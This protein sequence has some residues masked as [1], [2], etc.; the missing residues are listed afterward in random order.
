MNRILLSLGLALLS[1]PLLAADPVKVSYYKEIRPIFQQQCQGCH[2]P[3]KSLGGFVMT[4]HADLFK[5]GDSEQ[6]G[7]TA[8]KPA[9]SL[10]VKLLG[11]VPGRARMPKAKDPLAD[12]Q[13]KLITRWVA[14]GAVDDTPAS[15]KA[16]LVD[17][18]HPPVYEALPVI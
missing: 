2:Q 14:E 4:S 3:A 5:K 6:A 17:A 18:E 9:E 12:A 11:E 13:V 10:L 16:P 8:G 15:A 1:S 7:V